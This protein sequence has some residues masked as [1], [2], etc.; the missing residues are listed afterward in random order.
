MNQAF[1]DRDCDRADGPVS[2]HG[3]TARC[4][5]EEYGKVVFRIV[6]RKKHGA[7]HHVVAAWFKHQSC[8]NPVEVFEQILAFLEHVISSQKRNTAGNN[9]DGI[10]A[11]MRVYAAKGMTGRHF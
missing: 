7:G 6:R 11:S 1:L 4:L 8:A 9:S 10:A 5:D 3:K 2:A